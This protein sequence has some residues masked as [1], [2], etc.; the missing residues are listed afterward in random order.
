MCRKNVYQALLMDHYQNPRH[1]KSVKNAN[2][3][4]GSFNP[5]CGDIVSFEGRIENGILVAVGFS[6]KGCVIG[7]ATASL[8]AEYA[9]HKT[10]EQIIAFNESTIKNL[11]QVEL[12]LMR[13]KCALLP[14]QA[15]QKGIERYKIA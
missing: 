2:F 1:N 4:S 12:G 13:F 3:T 11:I 9:L 7:Q 8:L 14:L 6:G 5:S 10:V 15:L